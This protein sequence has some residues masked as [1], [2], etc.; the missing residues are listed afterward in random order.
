MNDKL[1]EEMLKDYTLRDLQVYSSVILSEHNATNNFIKQFKADHDSH[2]F[3]KNVI[4]WYIKKYQKF[5]DV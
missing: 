3:Y 4:K 2:Q 5:P 1:I